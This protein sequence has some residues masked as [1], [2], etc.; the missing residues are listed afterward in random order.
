[1]PNLILDIQEKNGYPGKKNN[2][3]GYFNHFP[4]SFL[5]PYGPVAD[6]PSETQI[7]EKVKPMNCKWLL[8]PKIAVSEFAET[9]SNLG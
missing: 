1:L 8:R 2:S 3:V 4:F 7:L 6:P 9:L 5:K